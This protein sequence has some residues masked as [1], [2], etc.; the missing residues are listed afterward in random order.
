M[1]NFNCY[2]REKTVAGQVFYE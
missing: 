1:P 2:T